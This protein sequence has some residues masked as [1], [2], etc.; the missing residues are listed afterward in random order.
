V[1]TCL[2]ISWNTSWNIAIQLLLFLGTIRYIG[3]TDFG[4]GTWLGVELRTPKGKNDGSV[5]GRR[6]FTCKQDHGLLVRPSKVT[7]RGINGAKLLGETESLN[8]STASGRRSRSSN[9]REMVT[10]NGQAKT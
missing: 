9:E 8:D 5:Q 2:A 6:Y 10:S 3:P 4:E 1:H 7:V